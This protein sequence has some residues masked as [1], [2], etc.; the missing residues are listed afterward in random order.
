M[1]HYVY[2]VTLVLCNALSEIL[3]PLLFAFLFARVFFSEM[4]GDA[5]IISGVVISIN[6]CVIE[7]STIKNRSLSANAM[8]IVYINS[9]CKC[10]LKFMI[11]HYPHSLEKQQ[12]S[13]ESK[14]KLNTNKGTNTIGF[15]TPDIVR[16]R[17]ALGRI[18]SFLKTDNS[19]L[20]NKTLLN[21]FNF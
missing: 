20:E 18:C 10:I 16:M 17:L 15:R 13:N 9:L 5:N 3:S 1:L 11:I 12:H 7:V 4:I 14:Y 2:Y 6:M 21:L 8:H 19:Y